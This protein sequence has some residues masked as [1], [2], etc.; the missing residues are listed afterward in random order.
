M[1]MPSLLW[2]KAWITRPLTGQRNCGASLAGAA[3]A[4]WSSDCAF[5]AGLAGR[6]AVSSSED[7]SAGAAWTGFGFSTLAVVTGLAGASVA[8]VTCGCGAAAT[9]FEG[10]WAT[11]L[12]CSG[13][14]VWR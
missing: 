7:S 8:G 12:N 4:T 9:F 13:V 6:L 2:P 14:T 10:L 3:S 11:G 1:L 5:G